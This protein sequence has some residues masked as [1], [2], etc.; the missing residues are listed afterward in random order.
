VKYLQDLGELRTREKLELERRYWAAPSRTLN[1]KI[2]TEQQVSIAFVWNMLW[3]IPFYEIISLY[4]LKENEINRAAAVLTQLLIH[5]DIPLRIL[6]QKSD[7]LLRLD[8]GTSLAV[9]RHLISRR[10]WD[11]DIT[12]R[13]RTNERLILLN[14]TE[15]D[16][17]SKRRLVA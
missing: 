12:K 15:I 13:I 4:P 16:L 9:V 1:L 7:R 3:V 17:Q 11:V 8:T 10:Y 14:S 6:T 5:E 2:M